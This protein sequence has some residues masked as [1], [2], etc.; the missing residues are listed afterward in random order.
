MPQTWES[1]IEATDLG[2]GTWTSRRFR[3]HH[4]LPDRAL[5]L[6]V[7][8]SGALSI[9]VESSADGRN[10]VDSGT[11][12]VGFSESFGPAQDGKDIIPFWSKT[13]DFLRFKFTVSGAALNVTSW[14][15]Q[16]K[17]PDRAK[18]YPDVRDVQIEYSSG[19]PIYVGEQPEMGAQD[20]DSTWY[21]TKID[22][23]GDVVT[24]VRHQLTSWNNR[25]SGWA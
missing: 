3:A 8:G 17:T 4:S 9:V 10:W 13:G 2:V 24:R 25:A 21:V 19:L 1:V 7:T 22:W 5:Q 18:I 20:T 23:T 11:K 14:L 15:I 12:L 6:G 16:G